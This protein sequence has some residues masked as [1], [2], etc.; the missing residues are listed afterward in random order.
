[1][2]QK[3]KMRYSFKDLAVLM[4]VSYKTFYNE[5]SGDVHLMQRLKSMGW[6]SYQRFRKEHVIEI[7]NVMGYPDGYERYNEKQ[8]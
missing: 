7:F 6:K 1:M 2:G 5:V 4:G 8:N 3:L